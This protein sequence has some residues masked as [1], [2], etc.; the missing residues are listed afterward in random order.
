MERSWSRVSR[1][2]L[3]L[4]AGAAGLGLLAGCGRLPGQPQAP[5][6]VHRVGILTFGA[7]DSTVPPAPGLSLGFDAFQEVLRDYGYVD[8]Q[9]LAIE[10]RNEIMLQ[11]TEVLQ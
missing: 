11:V 1:R 9:N 2:Q 3:V 6:R 5:A 8:G 7:S 4:G 10:Y